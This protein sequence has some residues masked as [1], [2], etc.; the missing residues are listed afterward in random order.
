MMLEGDVYVLVAGIVVISG[1]I[2]VVSQVL[3][4]VVHAIVDYCDINA[5]A[6]DARLPHRF[7]IDIRLAG[8]VEMPLTRVQ[9]VADQ[10]GVQLAC[11]GFA[12]IDEVGV[13]HILEGVDGVRDGIVGDTGRSADLDVVCSGPEIVANPKAVS[14]CAGRSNDV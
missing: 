8:I 2:D 4:G 5:F 9:R 12:F 3:V 13:P 7:D 14:V 1:R 6:L 10:R 11:F